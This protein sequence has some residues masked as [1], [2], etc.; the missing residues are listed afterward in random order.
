MEKLSS[1]DDLEFLKAETF[2]KMTENAKHANAR[3]SFCPYVKSAIF[4]G[5][6][7]MFSVTTVNN[8]LYS[9]GKSN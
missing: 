3:E 4:I 7:K 5:V 2:A 6:N 8:R 1:F 9:Y